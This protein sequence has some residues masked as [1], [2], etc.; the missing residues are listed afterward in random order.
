[1]MTIIANCKNYR[2]LSG[3]RLFELSKAA[4]RVTKETGVRI[5]I[6]SPASDISLLASKTKTPVYAQAIADAVVGAS[7]GAV[8][9]NAVRNSGAAGT[10]IN[11]SESR[12]NRYTVGKLN[13]EAVAVG[14]E[15][16]I[17]CENLKEV[18]LYARLQPTY[19]AIEPPELIGKGKSVTSLKPTLIV[20]SKQVAKKAGFNGDLLCGAGITNGEDARAAK[21][22]GADGVLAASSLAKAPNLYAALLDLARGLSG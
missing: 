2:E 18:R 17:C 20:D 21:E 14:L 5:I 10:I 11:H 16:C 12:R 13:E 19:L 9:A 22:L 1:M 7:T 4:E 15:R 6:A 3:G 8:I